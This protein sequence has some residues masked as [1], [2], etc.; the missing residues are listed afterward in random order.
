MTVSR[1][2]TAVETATTVELRVP[3]QP[4]NVRLARLALSGVAAVAG[5][6]PDELS[7]LKLAVSEVCTNVVLHAYPDGAEGEI[8]IRYTIGAEE[9]TVEVIDAGVGFDPSHVAMEPV[10]NPSEGHVGLVIARAVTDRIEI[11]SGPSGTRVVFS[12]RRAS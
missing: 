11:D 2:D 9:L 12:K 1:N 6:E 7:D 3:A 4:A 8:V 10:R 5:V